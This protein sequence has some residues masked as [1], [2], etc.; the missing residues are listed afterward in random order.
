[1]SYIALYNVYYFALLFNTP[2][3]RRVP[4]VKVVHQV[5]F[6]SQL[7]SVHKMLIADIWFVVRYLIRRIY[8]L[9]VEF[10][11]LQDHTANLPHFGLCFLVIAH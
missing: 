3:T 2:N 4:F 11:E 10:F 5:L 1:M 9:T 6:L 8:I 7:V